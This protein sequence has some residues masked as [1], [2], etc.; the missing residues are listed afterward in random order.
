MHGSV[1]KLLLMC[2]L[3]PLVKNKLGD[4]TSSDNYRAIAGGSLLLKIIDIVILLLEGHK[5]GFSELQFAYQAATSTSVCS[6]AVSTVIDTFNRS[7]SP[8]YAA[9]MD[10]SKAFDMV[11][12]SNLFQDLRKR[13]VSCVFLR[14]MMYIYCHQKC[15]VMWAGSRYKE[16]S[17]NNG[18]RQR[19]VSSAILFAVY[20]DEL[21]SLLK[22]S[23]LGC[24]IHSVFVGAFVF[25]DLWQQI[26]VTIT[27]QHMS[28]LRQ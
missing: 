9:T 21:L 24:H 7:G 23:R 11:E 14:L 12:W 15:E 6:W 19:A 13:D 22:Q 3:F 26:R 5:L 25:V 28:D 1:P 10:I 2:S 17:V 20:I 18:V 4:I 27:C 16:F 8:V